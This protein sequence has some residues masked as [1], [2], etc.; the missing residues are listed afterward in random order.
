MTREREGGLRAR[1]LA[2]AANS[3]TPADNRTPAKSPPPPASTASSRGTLAP[4][5]RTLIDEVIEAADVDANRDLLSAMLATSIQ[6]AQTTTDRLDLKIASAALSE[7]ADAFEVFRP[8][9][10]QRKVTLFGSARTQP[11]DPLYAQ[12]RA[13]ARLLAGEG[14]KVVTGA[15]P[16]I[17][18]AGMEGAGQDNSFGVNIR[19]PHEQGPN[20]FIAADPK[21][22]E[23]RYFFTRKL[24]LIKESQAYAVL[25]GGFGTLDEM[26]E[27]LTLLQ[28]GKAQPAPVVL[29]D[30]PGGAYWQRWLEF[31]TGSVQRSRLISPSDHALFHITDSVQD[32]ADKITAFYRNYHSARWVGDLLVLRMHVLPDEAEL[33]RLNNLFSDICATGRIEPARPF[34]PERATNDFLDLARLAFHYT[35]NHYG[36]LRELINA[37]NA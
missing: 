24:M 27:L 7:M 2:R 23:M 19:L 30:T 9:R 12:A 29:V 31:I 25:P 16:G 1:P 35:R 11:D 32:A 8:Y 17:M 22:V 18:A 4:E 36:R 34:Q 33:D 10:L 5:L 13:L 6:L 3:R 20:R 15:G 21:L 14:W 28:T 26:F 37:I